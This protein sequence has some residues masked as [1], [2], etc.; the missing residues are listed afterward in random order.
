MLSDV[1]LCLYH[2][3]LE[4]IVIK[5][6]LWGTLGVTLPGYVRVDEETGSVANDKGVFMVKDVVGSL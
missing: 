5:H 2:S 3:F 4:L 1:V 6:P